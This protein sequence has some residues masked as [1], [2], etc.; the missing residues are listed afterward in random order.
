MA[1]S[2]GGEQQ[3]FQGRQ[4]WLP[5]RQQISEKK[6]CTLM[7]YYWNIITV[8]LLLQMSWLYLSSFPC[9]WTSLVAAEIRSTWNSHPEISENANVVEKCE[10]VYCCCVVECRNTFLL[11]VSLVLELQLAEWLCACVFVSC[12]SVCLSV[13]QGSPW[14]YKS[15]KVLKFHTLK[16]KALKSP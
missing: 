13:C 14:S 16:Y 11:N 5:K 10:F 7:Y 4:H 12:L 6:C 8:C 15:L 9:M 3:P 1:A 2:G